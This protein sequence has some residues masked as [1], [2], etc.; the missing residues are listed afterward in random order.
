M[1][2]TYLSIGSN[3]DKERNITLSVSKLKHSKGI[4][5][6]RLSNIYYAQPIGYEDQ[7]YFLNFIAEIEADLTLKELL[8]RL[9]DIEKKQKRK[10]SIFWGPRT[11]DLDI[12][13][14]NQQIVKDRNLIIPHHHM[15]KRAFVLQPLNELAPSFIH[16]VLNKSVSQLLAE[17]KDTSNINLYG[18]WIKENKQWIIKKFET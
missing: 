11:I 14:Y 6:K 13:F 4:K 17:L 9:K 1:N 8:L 15:H 2:I 10:K 18:T 16:P 7:E 12:I 3:I 5:I